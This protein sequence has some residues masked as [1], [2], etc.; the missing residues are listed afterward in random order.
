MAGSDE[1]KIRYRLLVSSELYDEKFRQEIEKKTN[2]CC[3]SGAARLSSDSKL[4]IILEG[5]KRAVLKVFV[6]LLKEPR[7]A[8]IRRLESDA[9][10][11]IDEFEGRKFQT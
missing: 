4:E 8:K 5:E 7:L 11:F 2:Q 10:T 9:E 6:W 3:V 1:T